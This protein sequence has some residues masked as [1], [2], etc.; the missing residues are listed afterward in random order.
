MVV[1]LLG[2][3]SIRDTSSA[4]GIVA[5]F[6]RYTFVSLLHAEIYLIQRHATCVPSNVRDHACRLAR[7]LR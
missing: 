1:V 2:L 5:Y 4:S 7:L 6:T 3:V